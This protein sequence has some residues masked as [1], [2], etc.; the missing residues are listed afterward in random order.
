MIACATHAPA[1]P[2][3]GHG[4]ASRRRPPATNDDEL[5]YVEFP[6][7]SGTKMKRYV[8][9]WQLIEYRESV[10]LRANAARGTIR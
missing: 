7:H 9:G 2:T 1:S 3:L 4:R 10:Q 8:T 5:G 6:N